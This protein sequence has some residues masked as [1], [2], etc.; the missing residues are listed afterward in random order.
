ML[1]PQEKQDLDTYKTLTDNELLSLTPE[2]EAHIK[3][4]EAKENQ[5]ASTPTEQPSFGESF[6]SQLAPA[7]VAG[8]KSGA[9]PEQKWYEL[10]SGSSIKA[11]LSDALSLPLRIAS[12]DANAVVGAGMG[13]WNAPM[14]QKLSMA[15]QGVQEGL[16]A[17]FSPE[18]N[19]F[20][21]RTVKDP[22]TGALIIAA[23]VVGAMAAG[24]AEF[25]PVIANATGK[26]AQGVN[27]AS[28]VAS[29][30]LS[31]GASATGVQEATKASTGNVV[32]ADDAMKDLALNVGLGVT[33]EVL[34]SLGKAGVLKLIKAKYPNLAPGDEQIVLAKILGPINLATK[35]NA[36]NIVTAGNEE[37]SLYPK[38]V[39][40]IQDEL[41]SN[42]EVPAS[43]KEQV[44]LPSKYY[45]TPTSIPSSGAKEIT[46][47]SALFPRTNIPS[48]GFEPENTFGRTDIQMGYKSPTGI[49]EKDIAKVPVDEPYNQTTI[50]PEAKRAQEEQMW[51]EHGSQPVSEQPLFDRTKSNDWDVYSGKSDAPIDESKKLEDILASIPAD[52]VKP[53]YLS[54]KRR[55]NYEELAQQEQP[56]YPSNERPPVSIDESSLEPMVTERTPMKQAVATKGSL[57]NPNWQKPVMEYVDNLNANREAGKLTLPDYRK[58]LQ[59]VLALK[60]DLSKLG[61]DKPVN[62]E[63]LANILSAYK[64]TD[65]HDLT[66][67]IIQSI[68]N[69]AKSTA[70]NVL[71]NLKGMYPGTEIKIN[72]ATKKGLEEMAMGPIDIPT[73]RAAKTVASDNTQWSWEHPIASVGKE[74]SSIAPYSMKLLAEHGNKLPLANVARQSALFPS[75]TTS[76]NR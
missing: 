38:K 50:S 28:K 11:G 1:T 5:P 27:W 25:A 33:G 37:L 18:S 61:T 71:Y 36:N 65:A 44:A 62:M 75:D 41:L 70:S 63:Q 31:G 57:Q 51:N 14:G 76:R 66:M 17:G 49:S 68:A 30:A 46:E 53:P 45:N 8:I 22:V 55:A 35:S 4:L 74:I 48:K 13:A 9:I 3:A 21:E 19:G 67:N 43:V 73:Q 56:L 16:Q 29:G 24:G 26:L 64:G 60:E 15:G 20:L 39:A 47:S 42:P 69:D 34:A 52:D 7:T 54:P 72:P 10:P 12:G 32:T 2:D 6:M 23:P 58:Q 40:A 59:T